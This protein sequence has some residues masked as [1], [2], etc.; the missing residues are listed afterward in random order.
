[1]PSSIQLK[2]GALQPTDSAPPPPPPPEFWPMS[3]LTNVEQADQ[4][5][6]VNLVH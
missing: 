5:D 1:M 2:I 3:I 4:I 6:L